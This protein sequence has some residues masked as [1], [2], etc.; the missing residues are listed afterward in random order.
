MSPND[1]ARE[2][3]IARLA[4]SA[5]WRTVPAEVRPRESVWDYPR[6]PRV[7]PTTRRVWVVLGGVT[8]ADTRRA[9]RVL[10]TSH[11]PVYYIPPDD[12]RGEYLSPATLH[13]W[14]EF[15]GMASYVD[16]Q[17]GDRIVHDA[18]RCYHTPSPGY[19]DLA[20]YLAFYPGKMDACFVDGERVQS[21]ESDFCG[22]WLT[23]EIEGPFRGGRGTR[24]W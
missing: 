24:G 4:P 14:C 7:E 5:R 23:S 9:L 1:D 16:A 18:A 2:R 21:Q 12:V 17:V 19:E 15:K 8:F 13:T 3:D 11:P 6:P 20:D 10:E 22:G